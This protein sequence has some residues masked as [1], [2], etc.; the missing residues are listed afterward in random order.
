MS[1]HGI[2]K[3]TLNEIEAAQYIGMSRSWL[4]QSRCLKFKHAPPF[5]RLGYRIR[6]RIEELDQWKAQY[7]ESRDRYRKVKKY[8]IAKPPL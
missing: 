7:A 6:Y 5:L 2:L 3:M 1:I 8:P 4:R